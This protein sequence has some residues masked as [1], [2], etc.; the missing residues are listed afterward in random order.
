[1]RIVLC[2]RDLMLRDLLGMLLP[3][4]GHDVV[5]S[6]GRFEEALRLLAVVSA[7]V[8]LVDVRLVGPADLAA[9]DGC[10]EGRRR[11]RVLLLTDTRGRCVVVREAQMRSMVD[12][13]LDRTQDLLAW[14]Q[15]LAGSTAISASPRRS[16]RAAGKDVGA[17]QYRRTPV[18]VLTPREQEVLDRMVAGL[19]TVA[20]AADLG[21]S[22]ST[23]LSHVRSVLRKLGVNSRLQAVS[24]HLQTVEPEQTLVRA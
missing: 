8:L 14:E 1:M 12:E 21:V 2:D 15:A 3:Q 13:V 23:V 19:S 16:R 10:S 17:A 18:D 11:P 4:R 9:I 20:M 22:P 5:G 7:D 24:T 6:V